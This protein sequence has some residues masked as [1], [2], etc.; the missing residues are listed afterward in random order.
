MIDKN[1]A[2]LRR[3]R[4]TRL[5]IREIGAAGVVADQAFQESCVNRLNDG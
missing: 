5:K 4:Q 1:P 2:R 3:A